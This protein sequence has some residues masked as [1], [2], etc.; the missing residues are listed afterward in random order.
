MKATTRIIAVTATALTSLAVAQAAD[1]CT[2]TRTAWGLR[3]SDCKLSELYYGR[4]D[5]TLNTD[6]T[7][8]RVGLANLV[9]ADVDATAVD[10]TVSLSV[11]LLNNGNVNAG[12]FEVA[13]VTSVH[14][15]HNKGLQIS[16]TALPPVSIPGLPI[17][18]SA[19][20]YAGRVSLLSR[21]QDWDVCSTAAV[22]PPSSGAP[23][24]RVGEFNEDDN[25]WPPP[26]RE[27][28]CRVYGPNPNVV[29]PPPCL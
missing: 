18:A 9:A 5:L 6:P 27:G 20:A 11:E 19:K 10:K 29:G 26:M 4:Y 24:G 7:R 25:H 1:A 21:A 13:V 3:V 23:Y 2:L 8:P 22:D 12:P 15:P 28:C 14:D 16:S 17:G